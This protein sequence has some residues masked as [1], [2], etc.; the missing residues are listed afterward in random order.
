MAN[1]TKRRRSETQKVRKPRKSVMD[2]EPITMIVSGQPVLL[3]IDQE[4]KSHRLDS[5][6]FRKIGG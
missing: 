5:Y 1:Q 6:L 2:N 3:A 4:G